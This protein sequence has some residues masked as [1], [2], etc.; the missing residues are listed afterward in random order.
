MV[1]QITQENL[2]EAIREQPRWLTCYSTYA[3]VV[4]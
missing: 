2:E 3:Q 4:H 1:T